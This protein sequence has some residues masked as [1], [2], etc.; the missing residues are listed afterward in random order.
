M[1][2]PRSVPRLGAVHP[3]RPNLARRTAT[4]ATVLL[5]FPVLVL[6][7]PI[8]AI[9]ALLADL[10]TGPARLRFPRLLAMSIAYMACE[11]LAMLSAGVLWVGTGFGVWMDSGWSRRAHYRLQ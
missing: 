8:L 9:A 3:P 5:A 1:S 6:V 11:W 4:V 7:A 2:Q 10:A